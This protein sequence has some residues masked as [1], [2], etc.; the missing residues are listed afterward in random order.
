MWL[1]LQMCRRVDNS[2]SYIQSP[3]IYRTPLSVRHCA[4]VEN[5]VAWASS[6]LSFL[7]N[8]WDICKI[9]ELQINQCKKYL[10]G[11]WDTWFLWK[12]SPV[13]GYSVLGSQALQRRGIGTETI[14][15]YPKRGADEE[16]MYIQSFNKYLLRTCYVQ[17][18]MPGARPTSGNN[19]EI[20][21]YL[22]RVSG[23]IKMPNLMS[24]WSC[25]KWLEKKKTI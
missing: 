10:G 3:T 4:R 11:G 2:H 13:L 17:R 14:S 23:L 15:A 5:K 22:C 12:R 9:N 1:S 20:W 6:S 16:T 25:R 21:S 18:T 8:G 7:S 24:H 19:A